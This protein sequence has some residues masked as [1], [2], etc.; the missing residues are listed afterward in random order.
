MP[1]SE[2]CGR[3]GRHSPLAIHARSKSAPVLS[4]QGP[5]FARVVEARFTGTAIAVS[6]V[7]EA[8]AQNAANAER[9]SPTRSPAGKWALDRFAAI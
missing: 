9:D 3:Q 7:D 1:R 4:K 2:R 8:A 6:E 5:V